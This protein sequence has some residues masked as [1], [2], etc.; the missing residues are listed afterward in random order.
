MDNVIQV[1]NIQSVQQLPLSTSVQE[2]A[3]A[4]TKRALSFCASVRGEAVKALSKSGESVPFPKSSSG[5]NG[6]RD[7][8]TVSLKGQAGMFLALLA[9]LENIDSNQKYNAQGL[10][11]LA[12]AIST[13][14]EKASQGMMELISGPQATSDASLIAKALAD[15]QSGTGNYQEEM[16]S[17]TSSLTIHNTE[18]GQLNTFYTGLGNA[19]S[20]SSS[21]ASQTIQLDLQMYEQGP[22]SQL[23]TI[24]QIL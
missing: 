4:Q 15:A 3:A 6:G 14:N 22:Q 20:Q 19:L 2:E 9:F 23:Q 21:D 1:N 16:S 12:L 13:Q 18:L 7:S 5:S 11:P 24:A 17:A 10:I 8:D